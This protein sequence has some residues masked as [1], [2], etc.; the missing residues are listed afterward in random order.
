VAVGAQLVD[1]QRHVDGGVEHHQ[2]GDQGVELDGLLGL[3][4]L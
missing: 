3:G 2:I 1:D 4:L